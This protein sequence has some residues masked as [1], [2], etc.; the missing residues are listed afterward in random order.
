MVNDT[1]EAHPSNFSTT[2]ASR[3]YSKEKKRSGSPVATLKSHS[4]LIRTS[5]SFKKSLAKKR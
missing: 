2:E 5:R 1:I 4:K 3:N